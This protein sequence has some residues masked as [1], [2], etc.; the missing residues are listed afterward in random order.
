MKKT[1]LLDQA[2]TPDGSPLTLHEHDG[3]YLIGVGGVE[4]MSTRQHHSEERL[5][6]LRDDPEGDEGGLARRG[7][8]PSRSALS[9]AVSPP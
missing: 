5:A 3:A 1:T 9:R 8:P 6:E 4:L 2:T 7:S